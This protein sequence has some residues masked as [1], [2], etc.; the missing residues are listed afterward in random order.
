M[1]GVQNFYLPFKPLLEAADPGL[2]ARVDD[3]FAA[4]F[5]SVAP[6]APAGENGQ[7]SYQPYSDV[8]VVQRAPIQRAGYDLASILRQVGALLLI[9]AAYFVSA[10]LPRL[11]FCLFTM[12]L[13]IAT[14]LAASA[15]YVASF[16]PACGLLTVDMVHL[17]AATALGVEIEPE[18]EDEECE[19]KQ[20][21]ADIAAS[22]PQIQ[23]GLNYFRC[24]FLHPV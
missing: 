21:A 1:Q 7:I 6:Y 18:E 24:V 14:F 22:D 23:N 5:S 11:R 12:P 17:Q 16:H 2:A 10:F 15:G 19:P 9:P 13:T 3:A 8:T 4:A 20:E